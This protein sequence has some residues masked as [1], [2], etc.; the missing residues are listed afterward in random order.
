MAGQSPL[1]AGLAGGPSLW[2]GGQASTGGPLPLTSRAPSSRLLFR[3]GAPLAGATRG[4]TPSRGDAVDSR[5]STW[6]RGLL[7]LGR[8][9]LL[10]KEGRSKLLCSWVLGVAKIPSSAPLAS[11]ALWELASGSWLPFCSWL[12]AFPLG[13]VHSACNWFFFFFFLFFFGMPPPLSSSLAGKNLV[14]TDTSQSTSLVPRG[15]ARVGGT[16]RMSPVPD[17]SFSVPSN[18]TSFLTCPSLALPT[19]PGN[20]PEAYFD[21]NGSETVFRFL[22]I[23]RPIP[24]N[25][26]SALKGNVHLG[27]PHPHPLPA[28]GVHYTSTSARL[29]HDPRENSTTPG[30]NTLYASRPL[31]VMAFTLQ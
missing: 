3:T 2:G 23:F 30:D 6:I 11:G 21:V 10:C 5:P 29:E 13:P 16:H 8:F 20:L 26:T 17:R 7:F 9:L 27:R 14:P 24:G 28:S 31:R 18:P 19:M 4:A 25:K 12:V 22:L 1:S 15:P